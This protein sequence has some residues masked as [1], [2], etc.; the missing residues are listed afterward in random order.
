M[1]SYKK[2]ENHIEDALALEGYEIIR[3]QLTG[4]KRKI[5][6]IMI[7]RLD[8]AGITLDDCTKVSNLTSILLDQIDVISDAYNLEISSPGLDRP[9]VKPSHFM[10][11]VGSNVSVF[12][13]ILIKNR[14]KF[15]GVLEKC[16]ECG[17]TLQVSEPL[18][19]GSMEAQIP[20]SDIRSAKLKIDF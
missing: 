7:D 3:I 9:L 11:F 6:Q 20:F 5:L 12:T 1:D 16:D 17:I 14:K 8:G 10:K 15:I 19:D 18:V 2:I 13:H 4:V